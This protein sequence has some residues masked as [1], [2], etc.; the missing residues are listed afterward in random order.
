MLSRIL[1]KSRIIL[2]FGVICTVAFLFLNVWSPRFIEESVEGA[3]IDYRFKVRNLLRK[4][5]VPANIVIVEVDEKSLERYGRWP[6]KRTLQAK[7]IDKIM[8]GKPA[9]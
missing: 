8:S 9:V 1:T 5:V 2:V 4:P 7:L 3:F 6:W